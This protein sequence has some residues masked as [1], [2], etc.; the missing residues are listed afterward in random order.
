MSIP[1]KRL[2][3]YISEGSVDDLFKFRKRPVGSMEIV[4]LS[5]TAASIRIRMW[6][7]SLNQGKDSHGA[8]GCRSGADHGLSYM[9]KRVSNEADSSRDRPAE[10]GQSWA[11]RIFCFSF[12]FSFYEP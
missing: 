10:G 9:T 2:I 4:S 12:F 7:V 3:G 11:N 8:G 6:S 5:G 1:L